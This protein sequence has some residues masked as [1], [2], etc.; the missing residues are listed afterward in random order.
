M[1]MGLFVEKFEIDY[2]VVEGVFIDVVNVEVSQGLVVVVEKLIDVGCDQFFLI[3]VEV[4]GFVIIW[5]C[6]DSIDW[7]FY[8]LW[9]FL[10]FY[11]FF[12]LKVFG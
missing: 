12:L 7:V 3:D 4:L 10:I 5:F 8:Y 9:L 1:F 2:L 11:L 6:G